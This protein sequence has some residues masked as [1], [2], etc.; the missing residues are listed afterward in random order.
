MVARGVQMAY[1]AMASSGSVNGPVFWG[2]NTDF[3]VP[4]ARC[5]RTESKTTGCLL[6]IRWF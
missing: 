3:L 4:G 2:S 6:S 5:N 1:Q